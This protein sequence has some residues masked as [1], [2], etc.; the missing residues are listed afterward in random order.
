MLSYSLHNWVRKPVGASRIPFHSLNFL[1]CHPR[2]PGAWV[3]HRLVPEGTVMMTTAHD[4]GP[5][6]KAVCVDL[7]PDEAVESLHCLAPG[8][9]RVDFGG[10]PWIRDAAERGSR[11]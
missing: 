6:D 3:L 7:S 4:D 8:A 10:G 5:E 2:R 1:G 11:R 9:P